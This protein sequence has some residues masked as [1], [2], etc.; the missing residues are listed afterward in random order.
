MFKKKLFFQTRLFKF[1]YLRFFIKKKI[2]IYVIII[3]IYVKIFF[4]ILYFLSKN[5][6]YKKIFFIFYKKQQKYI[7][8]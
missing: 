6:K 1:L 3:Y 7:I 5:I 4:Y 8:L 2:F